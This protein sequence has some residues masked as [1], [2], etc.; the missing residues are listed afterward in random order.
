MNRKESS[1]RSSILTTQ[2]FAVPICYLTYSE[3]IFWALPFLYLIAVT[4]YYIHI[5]IRKGYIK[6]DNHDIDDDDSGPFIRGGSSSDSF[7]GFSGG[8]SGGGGSSNDW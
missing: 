6:A 3:N 7:G 8:S 2:A 5:A 1:Y 4:T